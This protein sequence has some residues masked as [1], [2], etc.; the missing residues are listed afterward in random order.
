MSSI[1]IPILIAS[2][3]GYQLDELKVK[4][5]DMINENDEI[6][7]VQFS[8]NGKYSCPS[9]CGVNH[10][11]TVEVCGDGCTKHHHNHYIHNFRNENIT[12]ASIKKMTYGEHDIQDL[13]KV[14]LKE[15]KEN[16]SK[17]MT[18]LLEN[19]T[20]SVERDKL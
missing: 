7:K 2:F 3:I 16:S 13:K 9:Y 8:K 6:V 1:L 20:S 19:Y 12:T 10:S 4:K 14:S 17:D 11:H 15:I 18:Q 5:Y